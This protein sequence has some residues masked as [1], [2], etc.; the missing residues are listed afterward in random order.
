MNLTLK[1][2]NNVFFEQ[3]IILYC[4]YASK[5]KKFM[6]VSIK[7][8]PDKKYFYYSNPQVVADAINELIEGVKA[9]NDNC[10][11]ID[12]HKMVVFINETALPYLPDSD[13][14]EYIIY[15][16]LLPN[17]SKIIPSYDSSIAR[18]ML[19]TV[20][21]QIEFYVDKIGLSNFPRSEYATKSGLAR[22][23]LGAV[24]PDIV[25]RDL[26][27]KVRKRHPKYN[28][29]YNFLRHLKPYG[30]NAIVSLNSTHKIY[31]NCLKLD[32]NSS[33]WVVPMIHNTGSNFTHYQCYNTKIDLDKEEYIVIIK[34]TEEGL[35]KIQKPKGNLP[36]W[37]ASSFSYNDCFTMETLKDEMTII[38]PTWEDLKFTYGITKKDVQIIK[39]ISVTPVP[40]LDGQRELY[41]RLHQDK[42]IAKNNKDELTT[43]TI[44]TNGHCLHGYGNGNW[45]TEVDGSEWY[46]NL[47]GY[48]PKKDPAT[49][50]PY[51][52]IL[53]NY[54]ATIM[55]EYARYH[56]L[57][58]INLFDTVYYYDTD[59]V[60]VPDT[61][62]NREKIKEYNEWIKSL[63]AQ[64]ELNYLDYTHDGHTIGFLELEA[65]YDAFYYTTGKEYFYVMNDK[66]YSTTAGYAKNTVAKHIEDDSELTGLDALEWLVQHPEYETP[67]IFLKNGTGIS[68]TTFKHHKYEKGLY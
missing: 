62:E 10:T 38:R 67:L 19:D 52:M 37:L 32:I 46:E 14:L 54:D 11:H 3:Y 48:H 13:Y 56:I 29:V 17:Y 61:E 8:E 42:A 9:F 49:Y 31:K 5:T 27:S 25:N 60:V 4:M 45:F 59:C 66:L 47:W 12:I 55:Y 18:C 16:D 50:R 57:R 28:I 20:A 6:S 64:N 63:Y 34:F 43:Q 65:K 40:F 2:Y 68:F 7:N 58:I 33:F 41:R 53:N 44:K 22:R 39:R 24:Y 15:D 30:A 23:Y 36:H 1:H 21:E 26:A 35:K 51:D